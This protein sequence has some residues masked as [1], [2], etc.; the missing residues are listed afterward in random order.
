MC[1]ICLD[2]WFA[3]HVA[4]AIGLFT[5]AAALI[6]RRSWHALLA[7]AMIA[8]AAAGLGM[9]RH[10]L[11]DRW[12]ASDHVVHHAGD[13]PALVRVVGQIAANPRIV[14]QADDR[15]VLF[16][17][18]PRTR[19]VLNAH[20]IETS[21]GRTPASGHI[22]VTINDA[23][24]AARTGD[25]VQLTGWLFRPRGPANPGE[26]DWARHN[27]RDG[28]LVRLTCDHAESVRIL[29]RPDTRTLSGHIERMRAHVRGLLVHNGFADND[30]AVGVVSAIVLGERS[31]V[32]RA[33]NDIFVRTGNAHFLAASGTNVA[34]LMLIG[35]GVM[36]L[37]GAAYRT[38]ALVVMVLIL[39]YAVLAEPEPS[40]GRATITGL[41]FCISILLHGR[42]TGINWL[43]CAAVIILLIDP[44]D[45]FRPAFQLSFLA[46]I[47]LL[48][49][50]P[51]I[52]DALASVLRRRRWSRLSEC[53]HP[54][55]D[56]P[57]RPAP[58][59]LS[60][61]MLSL[62][63]RGATRGLAQL[64]IASFAVWLIT[65]PLGCYLFD[66]LTPLGWL[67]TFV[68]WFF[69]FPVTLIGYLTLA[70][71]LV[72]PS[73]T[74][75]LSAALSACTGA[76]LG[77]VKLL[78]A[79]PGAQIDGRTPSILWVL[80]AYALLACWM[81]PSD[82]TARA[83][84]RTRGFAAP[85]GLL[86]LIWLTPPR[87][88]AGGRDAL[89]VWSLAVGDGT[90]TI[91]ELPDGRVIAYDLGSRS[92][93]DTG[94][95]CAALLA[96][97]GIRHVDAIVVSHANFDHY[98][99]IE[100]LARHV[101]IG[102]VHLND[103][104][105]PFADDEYHARRFLEVMAAAGIPIEKGGR[106]FELSG[107]GGLRIEPLWPPP[108]GDQRIL[109][110]N[111]A[112]TVLRIQ[113]QGRSILL[114]GDIAEFA[115]SRLLSGHRAGLRCDALFLPHHGSVVSNTAA[116]IDAA[117]PSVAI[118]SSGQTRRRSTSGIEQLVAPAAYYNTADHGCIHLTIRN[119]RIEHES[120]A[121]R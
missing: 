34:W 45:H 2:V 3:P 58:D 19:F 116:F 97:R 56:A 112:S 111:D 23:V 10:A 91:I 25:R 115:M 1:G 9:A 41:L 84:R 5:V 40:I 77:C 94:A 113:W 67:S 30:D 20:A 107:P 14:P 47:G 121:P 48:C 6:A 49:L 72:F 33:M 64:L 46:V 69:V 36:R 35:W 120:F 27:R 26:Y 24:L 81:W 37:C 78:A 92:D 75:L 8:T 118:R 99:G 117:A 18:P 85:A 11:A 95:T 98:S 50:Y 4:V 17:R 60:G 22:A 51:R 32:S 70:I 73:T 103:H 90:A 12:I 76:M 66:T 102:R 119:G 87:W 93:R 83:L 71:G 43:A 54:D 96:G 82:W 44:A 52:A 110:P 108:I 61:E 109:E 79:V 15:P 114:T 59:S 29:E 89:H 31:A 65:A 28:L 38:S 86:M 80:C 16:E 13:E 21:T 63:T 104:F 53:I 74:L 57:R 100:S 105:E 101:S 39:S 62:L 42:T 106:P 88:F 55:P 7:P 68:L